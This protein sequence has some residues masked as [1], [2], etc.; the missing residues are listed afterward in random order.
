MVWDA[1]SGETLDVAGQAPAGQLATAVADALGK[2][3]SSQMLPRATLEGHNGPPEA[4]HWKR[5]LSSR[6]LTIITLD[7]YFR[8]T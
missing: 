7:T 8:I 5:F 1:H 2:G 4:L 3:F 6:P